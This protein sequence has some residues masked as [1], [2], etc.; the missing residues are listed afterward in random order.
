MGGVCRAGTESGQQPSSLEH[1]LPGFCMPPAPTTRLPPPRSS[2]YRSDTAIRMATARAVRGEN[3]L[4]YANVIGGL[5]IIRYA[6]Q[7]L[8]AT[9]TGRHT[10]AVPRCSASLCGDAGLATG[11]PASVRGTA[12]QEFQRSCKND[13][14]RTRGWDRAAA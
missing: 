2:A 5:D 13:A 8:A 3:D 4:N 9:K 10:R 14:R 12:K 6:V 11:A 1:D 7:P